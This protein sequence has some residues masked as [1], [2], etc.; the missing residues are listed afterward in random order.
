MSDD[1]DRS[2]LRTFSPFS[3]AC[4]LLI[5]APFAPRLP[6][7]LAIKQ[8]NRNDHAPHSISSSPTT[9]SP[10]GLACTIGWIF[11]LSDCKSSQEALSEP[12]VAI[13]VSLQRFR[14]MRCGVLHPATGSQ[15]HYLNNY[16]YPRLPNAGLGGQEYNCMQP[17]RIGFAG[18]PILQPIQY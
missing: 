10:W 9:V 8:T 17:H 1:S 16:H 5:P 18:I 4:W 6:V 14:K 7:C 13:A 3:L 2:Y 12:Q 11:H 15:N